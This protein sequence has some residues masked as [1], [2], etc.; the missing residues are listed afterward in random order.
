[1]RLRNHMI[2]YVLILVGMVGLTVGETVSRFNESIKYR[3]LSLVGCPEGID[4]LEV[5]FV[6]G[7]QFSRK[8]SPRLST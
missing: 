4:S 3:S 8:Y 6:V 1:M 2:L 5:Y 7:I